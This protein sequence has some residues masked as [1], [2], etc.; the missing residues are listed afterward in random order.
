MFSWA[1]AEIYILHYQ[2]LKYIIRD[3]RVNLLITYI[4]NLH[5]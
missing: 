1:F 2:N 5:N 3:L 4:I